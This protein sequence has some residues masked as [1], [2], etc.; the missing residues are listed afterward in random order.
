MS[1]QENIIYC[2]ECTHCFRSGRSKTGYACE[3]WGHDDFACDTELTGFCHKG[4]A[5]T[6]FALLTLFDER[7]KAE[8][9]LDQMIQTAK[10]YGVVLVSDFK[11]LVN[12]KA[13][14]NDSH[15]GWLEHII[16][17]AQIEPAREG[18]YLNLPKP[19]PIE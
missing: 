6:G 16:I 18:W 3:V 5:S 15:F 13:S 19:L 12:A 17:E 4:K 11:E 1:T 2:R 10:W 14:I 7:C 8:K 9:V